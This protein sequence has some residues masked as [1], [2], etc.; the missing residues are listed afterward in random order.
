M[1]KKFLKDGSGKIHIDNK[2]GLPLQV[3]VEGMPTF[4]Y[5]MSEV[6]ADPTKIDWDCFWFDDCDISTSDFAAGMGGVETAGTTR[7]LITFNFEN[8]TVW[9]LCANYQRF[10]NYGFGFSGSYGNGSCYKYY[11]YSKSKSTYFKYLC[12]RSPIASFT[13]NEIFASVDEEKRRKL[14]DHILCGTLSSMCLKDSDGKKLTD[15][16]GKPLLAN[17]KKPTFKYTMSEV[18]A[19]PTKT[20]WNCFW[21]DDYDY[22]A[23]SDG[24]NN[25]RYGTGCGNT[26]GASRLL[27]TFNLENGTPVALSAYNG[28]WTNYGFGRVATYN[29]MSYRQWGN[30]SQN[31]NNYFKYLVLN[32]NIAS[33]TLNERFMQI[34]E[35]TRRKVTDHIMCGTI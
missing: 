29:C 21:F 11:S 7:T 18:V 1:T 34:S 15:K 31:N 10:S 5:T 24:R 22:E 20:D 19:D 33:I 32:D 14:T 17:T 2:T 9:R 3:E 12:L 23:S 6:I 13:V 25:F 4:K 8:G 26:N 35:E 16:T 27:M 30:H 28:S